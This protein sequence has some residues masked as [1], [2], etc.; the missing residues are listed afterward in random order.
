MRRCFFD[1][2]THFRKQKTSQSIC[3]SRL[4]PKI[5]FTFGGVAVK[6]FFPFMGSWLKIPVIITSYLHVSR[7]SLANQFYIHLSWSTRIWY[8]IPWLHLIAFW[9]S[10][11]TQVETMNPSKSE[12]Q[13]LKFNG[14]QSWNF[15]L[16]IFWPSARLHK[17]RN[18]VWL[19]PHGLRPIRSTHRIITFDSDFRAHWVNRWQA[20]SG[21]WNS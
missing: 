1:S 14:L 3:T 17:S 6:P 16:L 18:V 15:Q 10:W 11:E 2:L 20:H 13:A 19:L 7:Q 5:E 4:F 21:W 9:E 12:E 8:G